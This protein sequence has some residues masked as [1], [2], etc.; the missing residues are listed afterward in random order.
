MNEFSF[1]LIG[2]FREI[3]KKKLFIIILTV[4]ALII[5][6][7]FCQLQQKKYTSETVFIVKNPLLIDRNYVFRN[8]SYEHKDFFAIP[9]DVDHVKTIAKSDGMIWHLIEKFDLGK[10]YNMPVDDKLVKLVKGNFKA[11]MEDT[12]NIQL[13]YSDPDPK[14]AAAVTNAA[15]EYLEQTFLNY[16]L[17]TNKDITASLRDKI[18]AI[19]DTI[20]RL[21]DSIKSIRT[22]TGSYSQLLPARSNTIAAAQSATPQS[23][24][25]L[26]HLQEITVVKDQM[27]KDV[28]QYRS[29]I[30]EYEVMASGKIHIFYVV[31]EAYVPSVASHPKTLIIV[32]AC[33]L[34][35]FFFACVLVLIA[36]FYKK[37]M[38][39]D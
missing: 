34:A 26:E 39:Q 11:L 31:Q 4:L 9:D 8:T 27:V 15:R 35:T 21:D 1:D 33:T 14:R 6:F 25:A 19:T 7:I 24:E 3:F 37:V 16:F 38:K 30:N 18:A 36:A 22:A 17:I 29:L 12:K 23:A 32:A 10:A 13:F 5:S 28:A 20:S 2:I